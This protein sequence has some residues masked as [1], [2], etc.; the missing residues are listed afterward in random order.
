MLTRRA[1]P[2]LVLCALLATVSVAHARTVAVTISSSA[3][4]VH[5][6]KGDMLRVTL[7]EV[8]DGGYHWRTLAKSSPAVLKIVSSIYRPP[9]LAPGETGGSGRRINRY[10]AV[11]TGRSEVLLGEFG[12]QSRSTPVT[13]FKL[14]VVVS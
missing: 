12:P 5:L 14:T 3:K 13:V 7:R 8:Q 11:G 9:H 1:S 10:H 6:H 4:T 2:L